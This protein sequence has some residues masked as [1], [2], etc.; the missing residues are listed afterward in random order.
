MCNSQQRNKFRTLL[1]VLFTAF[2]F[3]R[4]F[5]LQVQQAD[6][7]K[8]Q[9][10]VSQTEMLVRGERL[11][12]GLVY[13][14]PESVNCAGC[15]NTRVSDTLN[16]NPDALEISR[17][18]LKKNADDLGKVLLKPSGTKMSQSHRNIHLTAQEIAMVKAYMDKFT[19]IG[20]APDK[21]VITHIFLFIVA[22]VLFLLAVTD[23]MIFKILKRKWINHVVWVATG[24]FLTYELAANAIAVGRSQN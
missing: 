11:F 17:K 21:P 14:A 2:T 7:A 18:Y 24:A 23:L 6:S 16:W 12:Y 13:P 10:V 8:S 1:I 19:E 5:P 3:S 22:T 9:M 15:H 4:A 20:L